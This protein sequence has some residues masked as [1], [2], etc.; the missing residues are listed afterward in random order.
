MVHRPG[1]LP[2]RY[3]GEE[4]VVVL[5]QTDATGAANVAEKMRAQV[6]A[7]RI[8]HASSQ[9]SDRVTI[10]I[11]VAAVVPPEKSEPA[12][13]IAAADQALYRA[14][15]EGRNRVRSHGEESVGK[16]S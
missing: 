14:K 5:P 7:L 6:E 4:F 11:G 8:P 10:S 15:R 3:G 13:L 12:V 2:G 16:K 9:V 1:D